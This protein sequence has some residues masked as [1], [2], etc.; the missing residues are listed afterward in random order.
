MVARIEQ[1]NVLDFTWEPKFCIS[2]GSRSASNLLI[3]ANQKTFHFFKVVTH[4]WVFNTLSN[5]FLMKALSNNVR[6]IPILKNILKG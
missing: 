5:D 3:T 4:D 2:L 1:G 6:E